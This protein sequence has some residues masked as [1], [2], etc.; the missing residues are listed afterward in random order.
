MV[1]VSEEQ[2]SELITRLQ[3]A[4]VPYGVIGEIGG[5]SLSIEGKLYVP[6]PQ[7]A[8]TFSQSLEKMVKQG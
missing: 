5:E 8:C 3:Q 1:S 7:N 2:V 6:V 4:Q